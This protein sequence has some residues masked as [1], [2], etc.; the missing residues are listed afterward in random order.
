MHAR[1][2]ALVA[3]FSLRAQGPLAPVARWLTA[4]VR[5][6]DGEIIE[7]LHERDRR[8]GG[9]GASLQDRSLHITSERAVS[10]P[11]RLERLQALHV[12]PEENHHVPSH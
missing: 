2:Q 5:L 9:G 11:D 6:Y 10:L 8:V 4:M 1:M 3:G 12:S 7:L